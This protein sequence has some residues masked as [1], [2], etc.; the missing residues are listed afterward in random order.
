M[1]LLHAGLHFSKIERAAF[2]Y[3]SGSQRFPRAKK[4]G[5]DFEVSQ[6]A[7]GEKRCGDDSAVLHAVQHDDENGQQAV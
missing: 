6:G 2:I 1:L 7:G 4:R 5:L 3:F